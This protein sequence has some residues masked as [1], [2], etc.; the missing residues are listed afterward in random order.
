MFPYW[1]WRFWDAS[2]SIGVHRSSPRRAMAA[3]ARS[4]PSRGCGAGRTIN[5]PR[6]TSST[7]SS[8]NPHCSRTARG[9]RIPRELPMRMMRVL[10]DSVVVVDCRSPWLRIRFVITMYPLYGHGQTHASSDLLGP[11]PL[12]RGGGKDVSAGTGKRSASVPGGAGLR[13]SDRHSPSF[14]GPDRRT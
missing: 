5:R 4:Q 6:S 2:R 14:S 7:A 13:F 1:T 11:A 10:M 9:M 8:S 12:R 3:K